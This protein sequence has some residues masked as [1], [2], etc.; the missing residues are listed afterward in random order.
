MNMTEPMPSRTHRIACWL[1]ILATLALMFSP[2]V[3]NAAEFP[4]F[5]IMVFSAEMRRRLVLAWRQPMTK[6]ALAFYAVTCIGMLYSVAP[7]HE[8]VHIWAGWSKLLLIPIA[9]ALFDDPRWKDRFL[10]P[11]IGVVTI[12]AVISFGAWFAGYSTFIEP[13]VPG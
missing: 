1:T 6:G 7:L 9:L 8:M 3:V 12:C 10:L 13:G 11:F 5:A 4:L 2:P